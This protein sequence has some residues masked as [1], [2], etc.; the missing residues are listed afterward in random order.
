MK[1]MDILVKEGA[2]LDLASDTKDAGLEEMARAVAAAEPSLNATRLLEV[3]QDR[4]GLQ[5][6]VTR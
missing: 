3:R 2:I 4:E 5:T 1:I 6:W